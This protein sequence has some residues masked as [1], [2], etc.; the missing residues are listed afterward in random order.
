MNGEITKALQGFQGAAS[1]L[2]ESLLPQVY[3]EL[4]R[5]ARSKID[6]ERDVITMGATGLLHEAYTA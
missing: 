6:R 4:K 3:S 2:M 5:L 1:P